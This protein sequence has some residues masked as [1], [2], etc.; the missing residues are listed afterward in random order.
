PLH[1]SQSPVL[2]SSHCS[3]HSRTPLPQRSILQ[4]REQPSHESVLPSSHSSPAEASME[5]PPQPGTM[6]PPHGMRPGLGTWLTGGS[7]TPPARLGGIAGSRNSMRF[8]RPANMRPATL[9]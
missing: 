5:P 6:G 8:S 2:P 9:I 1:R 7:N 3:A 4:D